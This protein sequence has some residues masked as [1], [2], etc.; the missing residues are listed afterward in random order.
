[1]NRARNSNPCFQCRVRER[2][3]AFTLIE[4][5]VVI[6][7]IAIL[8][9]LVLPALSAAKSKALAIVCVNNVRQ[10]GLSYA[11]YV[12][13]HGLPKFTET[14]WPLDKGDWH[15]YLEPNY[16]TDPKVRLCPVTREDPNKRPAVP[17]TGFPGGSAY[18]NDYLGTAD[19]PYR[20][21]TEEYGEGPFLHIAARWVSSSYGLNTWV[22]PQTDWKDRSTAG[23]LFRHESDIQR[24]SLTPVFG[25]A[26]DFSPLPVV[27][28]R[29]ARDLYSPAGAGYDISDFQL[30]LREPWPRAQR[31]ARGAWATSGTVGEQPGLFRWPRRAREA[32]QSLELLLAQRLGTAAYAAQVEVQCARIFFTARSS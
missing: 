3:H 12:A 7:V 26:A 11:L 15:S 29:P 10:L 20:M 23:F 19:M 18:R 1:M 25:D 27:T 13:D 28:S 21:L 30:A 4:L 8:A 17:R 22:R 6:A 9:S 5:L 24:P 32:R 16:L 2:S 14:T 31:P